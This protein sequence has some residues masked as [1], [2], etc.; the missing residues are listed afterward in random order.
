MKKVLWIAFSITSLLFL[1]AGCS[2][3]NN[4]DGD[5]TNNAG[6]SN[7][8]SSETNGNNTNDSETNTNDSEVAAGEPGG[9]VSIPI[10]AD[11]TFNPWHPNAFAESNV[12]NR[13]LFSGLTKPGLDLVPEGDLAEDWETSDDQLEWTFHLRDDVLW[14]DGEPF[15]AE[16][17]AFT[18]NEITLN[19]ELGANNSSYFNEVNEVEAVDDHTVIFHMNSPVAAMPAYLS[20]N[21]EIIPKHIFEGEED[22]WSVNSFNKDNP[23]G[24]GPFKMSEYTSGQSVL[25]ERYD[26]YHGE[27]AL[28]DEVEYRVLSDVNTHVA[29]IMS[30]E[31]SIFAL[32]DLASVEQLENTEGI[33]VLSRETP[34]FFWISLNQED[35]RFQDT[36]VRQAMVHAI[37]RQNIIDTTL[38]GFGTIANHGI[39]PA[40]EEYYNPDVP[41][42]EYDPD[43][44]IELLAEA[45]WEQNEDGILERDGETFE[46]DF[47][48]GIQGDL[49]PI[50]QLVQQYLIAVGFDINLETMEWNTMI[51]KVVIDRDYEMSLN[52][53][54]YPADPDLYA[55]L[56]SSNAGTG[57]NI[58]GYQNDEMDALLEAGSQESEVADRVEIYQE[59]QELM[60][61]EQPYLFLW[62]P[63]E[64]QIRIDSLQGVPELAFGDALHYINEWYLQE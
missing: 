46:I 40:L 41:G 3:D 23:I 1:A 53:W 17:V 55:Y 62:Y 22:P 6:A 36:E 39:A 35:E 63:Q 9:R 56:H 14:H 18:F 2:F 15:T 28:L 27:T 49:E 16:D 12:I 21:T 38:Q 54:R 30:G 32:D 61:V 20:F 8:E 25:L 58:P 44:A 13:V 57:N 60:A 33:D 34:R 29:Q 42:L 51:D 47:E 43:R 11:P 7:N 4:D 52:W 10:V 5:V 37:D 59:L 24:T 48:I 19:D 26:D 31:L 50:S 64:A 45:G